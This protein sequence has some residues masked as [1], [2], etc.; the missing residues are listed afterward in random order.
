MRR[1]PPLPAMVMVGDVRSL[2]ID[3]EDRLKKEEDSS[4]IVRRERGAFSR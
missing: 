2:K 3:F 4:K 1:R